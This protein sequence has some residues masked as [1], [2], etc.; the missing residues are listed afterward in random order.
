[1]LGKVK[2]VARNIILSSFGPFSPVK[3]GTFFLNGHFVTK[4]NLPLEH[5]A[6]LFEKQLK[7]L[8]KEFDFVSPGEALANMTQKAYKLLCFTFD[9]GF[10]DNL[11][12]IA[13]VAERFNTKCLFFV[14]PD[15]I[16]LPDEKAGKVLQ[17][18]YLVDF[19]K[20]FLTKEQ[21]IELSRRGHTIGS[22]TSSHMRMTIDD[23]SVI[24]DQLIRSKTDIEA[25]IKQECNTFAHPF[26]GMN[27]LSEKAL[28]T[29]LETYTFVF[30]STVSNKSFEA[31]RKVIN[32]R[33]FEGNWPVSHIKYFLSRRT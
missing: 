16:G 21:V 25:I 19:T 29:A 22:H 32:R 33:H 30:A 24:N 8:S 12:V 4:E 14:N 13:P 9:D 27:H 3:A 20:F 18:N 15:F 7:E 1:M 2:G 10:S 11:S 5:Q 6:S 23:Q 17:E 31:D 26:G 28:Q